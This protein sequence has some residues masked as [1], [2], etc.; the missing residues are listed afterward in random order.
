MNGRFANINMYTQMTEK[1]KK[2]IGP[3]LGLNIHK[4]LRTE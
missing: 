3:K 1:K 2:K 4:Q